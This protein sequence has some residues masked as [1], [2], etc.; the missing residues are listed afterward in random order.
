[1]VSRDRGMIAAGAV[2]V[3]TAF[4]LLYVFN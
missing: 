1:M 2:W 4:A 3:V